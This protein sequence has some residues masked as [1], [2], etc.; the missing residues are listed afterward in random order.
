MHDEIRPALFD[1]QFK[2]FGKLILSRENAAFYA[3]RLSRSRSSPS[4][5]RWTGLS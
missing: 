5:R 3:A 1:E 4:P 2:L